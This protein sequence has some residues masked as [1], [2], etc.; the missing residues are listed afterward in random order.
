MDRMAIQRLMSI[1][2]ATVARIILTLTTGEDLR[3]EVR[4]TNADRG[5]TDRPVTPNDPQPK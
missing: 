5:H 1:M 4:R 2:I 3:M